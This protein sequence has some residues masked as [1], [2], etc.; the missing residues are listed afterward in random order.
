[1]AYADDSVSFSD[2]PIVIAPPQDT[3]IVINEEKSSY[4]VVNGE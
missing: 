2:Q 4:I 1:V 3:G